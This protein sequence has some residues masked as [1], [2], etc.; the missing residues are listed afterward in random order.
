MA[1]PPLTEEE[2]AKLQKGLGSL[3][4][5][6]RELRNTI[7]KHMIAQG[8]PAIM[9]TS[10]TLHKEVSETDVYEHGICRLNLNFWNAA[11][12]E[13][14]PCFK[15]SPFVVNKIRN[16]AIR[17]D[18]RFNSGDEY[19]TPEIGILDPFHG[20]LVHRGTCTLSFECWGETKRMFQQDVLRK[21]QAYTGFDEV[22]VA[23]DCVD[24]LPSQK[25][26]EDMEKFS[27]QQI[28]ECG[29]KKE[30]MRAVWNELKRD[31][32]LVEGGKWQKDRFTPMTFRP[33]KGLRRKAGLGIVEMATGGVFLS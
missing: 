13:L 20:T 19:P 25:W 24:Q 23:I 30:A 21:V 31:M 1:P 8:S 12:E 26:P 6:P 27:V 2:H 28:L 14:K 22:E 4:D 16:V 10:S 32:S 5:L 29:S 7:Y 18:T 33:R 11:T 9:Q 17:V 15:P 3:Y